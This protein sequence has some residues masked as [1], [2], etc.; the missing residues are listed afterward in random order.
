VIFWH[1]LTH[2]SKLKTLLYVIENDL[3]NF[4]TILQK[5]LLGKSSQALEQA[6]QESGGVTVLRD[7]Q[8]S[9]RCSTERHG[10]WAW[11]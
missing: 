5:F 4:V 1:T 6:A 11:W 3:V 2:L 8:E 9:C 7:V 10:W